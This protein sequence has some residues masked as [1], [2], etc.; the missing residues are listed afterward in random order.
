MIHEDKDILR[1]TAHIE[2]PVFW[3]HLRSCSRCLC[4]RCHIQHEHGWDGADLFRVNTYWSVALDEAGKCGN[5]LPAEV[6]PAQALARYVRSEEAHHPRVA[7]W[8][9]SKGLYHGSAYAHVDTTYNIG[10]DH[11]ERCPMKAGQFGIRR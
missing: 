10:G 1:H 5:V 3:Q 8:L 9:Y 7:L 2:H 6:A 11:F 4:R